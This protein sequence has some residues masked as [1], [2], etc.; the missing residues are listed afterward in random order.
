MALSTLI[1][2]SIFIEKNEGQ[3]KE[4]GNP[5]IGKKDVCKG[6]GFLFQMSAIN[7]PSQGEYLSALR[8]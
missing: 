6:V 5:C 1:V 3:G 2:W 8:A 4:N 7:E